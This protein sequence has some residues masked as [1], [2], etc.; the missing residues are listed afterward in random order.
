[1]LDIVGSDFRAGVSY[2]TAMTAF[3]DVLDIVMQPRGPWSVNRNHPAHPPPFNDQHYSNQIFILATDH[4]QQGFRSAQY[5][6]L[7]H[8]RMLREQVDR[9]QGQ[10]R[11]VESLFSFDDMMCIRSFVNRTMLS[12]QARVNEGRIGKSYY[13]RL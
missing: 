9:Y 6:A 7:V 3:A 5:R 12:I 13:T 2:M 11:M 8:S 4:P 1:M 10:W